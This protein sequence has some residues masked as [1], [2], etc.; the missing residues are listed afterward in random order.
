MRE[1][2]GYSWSSNVTDAP[3]ALSMLE[4]MWLVLTRY[5]SHWW[6]W[7]HQRATILQLWSLC[8]TSDF[9]LLILK[10]I[11]C[12]Q[13]HLPGNSL[14]KTVTP[15]VKAP[16]LISRGQD[17]GLVSLKGTRL[18]YVTCAI[19]PEN[20][21]TVWKRFGLKLFRSSGLC[22]HLPQSNSPPCR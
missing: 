21:V 7:R 17:G 2:E 15:S 12:W 1:I 11:M 5:R 9:I 8:H 13:Q 22:F 19:N 3:S 6:K 14:E 16:E 4:H 18:D 10:N 20:L